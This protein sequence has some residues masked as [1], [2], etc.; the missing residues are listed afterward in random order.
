MSLWSV[1]PVWS[2]ALGP[3]R[4]GA[5]RDELAEDE[6]EVQ[7]VKAEIDW[8]AAELWGLSQQELEDI[9]ASL[10]DLR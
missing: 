1:A 7:E 2:P 8:V 6:D 3:P 4:A 10:A 9:Q 5:K